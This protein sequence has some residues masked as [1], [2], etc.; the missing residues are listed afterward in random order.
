VKSISILNVVTNQLVDYTKILKN[1]DM[2]GEK[3]S[4]PIIRLL[5]W[6]F[7][8]LANLDLLQSLHIDVSYNLQRLRRCCQWI[9]TENKNVSE[10]VNSALFI[11]KLIIER[12]FNQL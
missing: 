9:L 5:E 7:A 1:E 2:T 3:E 4:I 6:C 11:I 10:H 8:A 12:Y